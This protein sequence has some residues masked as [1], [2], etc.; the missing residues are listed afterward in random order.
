LAIKPIVAGMKSA[1]KAVLKQSFWQT[2][3]FLFTMS[4]GEPG[5]EPGYARYK[6]ILLIIGWSPNVA[7]FGGS[8]LKIGPVGSENFKTLIPNWLHFIPTISTSL[9]ATC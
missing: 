1:F 9:P 3:V 7:L 2:Y 5:D 4:I 6:A 8:Y